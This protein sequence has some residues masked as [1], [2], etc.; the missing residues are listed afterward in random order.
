MLQK[1]REM[2][3]YHQIRSGVYDGQKISLQYLE[4]ILKQKHLYSIKQLDKKGIKVTGN[5]LEID[6][7]IADRH[8]YIYLNLGTVVAPKS[9]KQLTVEIPQKLITDKSCDGFFDNDL[10]S[11][12]NNNHNPDVDSWKKSIITIDGGIQVSAALVQ[13]Q[14]NKHYE[15]YISTSIGGT[16]TYGYLKSD[17]MAKT[18]RLSIYFD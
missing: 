7:G 11:F 17:R 12:N 8:A 6:K 1:F 5:T 16:P 18:R 15:K 9:K 13:T 14:F 10:V 4:N 3:F 2:P